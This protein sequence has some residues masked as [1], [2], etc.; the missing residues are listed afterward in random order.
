MTLI[1]EDW[2]WI[3]GLVMHWSI[4]DWSKIGNELDRRIQWLTRISLRSN[5]S[6]LEGQ[7]ELN[8]AVLR[9]VVGPL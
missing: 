7:W 6:T 1:D 9:P 8:H 2:G 5:G 3:E 4:A